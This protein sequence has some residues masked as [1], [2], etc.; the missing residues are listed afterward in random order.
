MKRFIPSVFTPIAR[1]VYHRF[2][3]AS[4]RVQFWWADHF[5]PS[6][7]D[8]PLPPAILRYRVSELLLVDRFFQIGEACAR[9][10]QQCTN[11]MGL[12]L[13]EAHRVLDFGCGCG[14][15]I[16]W[17]MRNCG[18]EFHGADVDAEA[19]E[20]CNRHLQPGCFVANGPEPPLPYPAGHFD[21]IYC[22]SV[23]THL[24]ERMQDDWL[25]EL[26]RI[27]KPGGVLLI[28]VF[29]EGAREALDPEGRTALAT[30]GFAHRRSRKLRGLLPDWY[31]TTVHSREYIVNRLAASFKEV[32]YFE[33]PD[34]L[35]DFIAAR[36]SN[37][38]AP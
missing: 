28:T 6:P 10:I 16:G 36:K 34:G 21:V 15:T 33:V 14:R 12:N 27:L 11:E 3:R 23:F 38:D 26:G 1:A 19:I 32:R 2:F 35:Q 25:A 18:A 7:S 5:G 9:L 4:L 22:V 30:H 17:F 31:Q 13:A 8:L 29:G 37:H 24:N 20:W